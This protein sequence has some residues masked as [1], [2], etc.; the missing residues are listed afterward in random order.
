MKKYENVAIEVVRKLINKE[1]K[2]D[3]IINFVEIENDEVLEMFFACVEQFGITE[4]NI[5]GL[6]KY[7]LFIYKEDSKYCFIENNSECKIDKEK[8]VDERW[9]CLG[10]DD[11]EESYI[12]QFES[13]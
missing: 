7:D 6:C 10:Y 1:I 3:E 5:F 4:K 2:E 12:I 13:V 9:Y 11:Y 8:I